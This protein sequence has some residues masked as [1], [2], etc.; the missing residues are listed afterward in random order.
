MSY[1]TFYD[2]TDFL[3]VLHL[4]GIVERTTLIRRYAK[5]QEDLQYKTNILEK[6]V[7]TGKQTE[8]SVLH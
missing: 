2:A 7:N 4:K 6:Y 5:I 1:N 8:N 3:T